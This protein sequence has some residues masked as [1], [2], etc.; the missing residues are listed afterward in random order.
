MTT[1]VCYQCPCTC[2]LVDESR[3]VQQAHQHARAFVDK[4]DET[5]NC[6]TCGSHHASISAI[7]ALVL[8][9]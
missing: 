3:A 8:G 4:V 2:D 5:G 6:F 1:I 7:L 9:K